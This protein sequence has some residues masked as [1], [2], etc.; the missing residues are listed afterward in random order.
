MLAAPEQEDVANGGLAPTEPGGDLPS[1]PPGRGHAVREERGQRLARQ[2]EAKL[3]RDALEGIPLGVVPHLRFRQR[4]SIHVDPLE[5]AAEAHRERE[6]W[7]PCE[8]D[9]LLPP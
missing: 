2:R 4:L 3:L 1:Q 9:P 8:P 5:L 6:R 7:L